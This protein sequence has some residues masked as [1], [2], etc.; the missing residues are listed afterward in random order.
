M[1]LI[2]LKA[3]NFK[4]L[5]DFE[6]NFQDGLNVIVGEN[7]QGKTT[8]LQ[9]IEAALFGPT[10]VPGKKENIPTWGQTKFTLTLTFVTHEATSPEDD[11]YYSLTRT[12]TT[13][14]LERFGYGEEELLANGNTPV[15]K[16][17]EELL[18]L[19]A[20]DYNLFMQSKQGET[21]GVLTF[22]AS[23]LNQKV[24]EF[25]GVSLIDAIQR[26]ANELSATAK[27]SS[28]ALVVDE[29]YM[30]DTSVK[31]YA[32]ENSHAVAVSTYE[33]AQD[34]VANYQA[35]IAVQPAVSSEALSKAQREAMR[36]ASSLR[37]A[38]ADYERAIGGSAAADQAVIDA[39]S[40]VVVGDLTEAVKVARS[41]LA[42]ARSNLS[43]L[44]E[45]L[46]SAINAEAQLEQAQHDLSECPDVSDALAVA[47]TN[48]I[49]A[50]SNLEAAQGSLAA[51]RA[52][53]KNLRLLEEG[54]ACPT[55]GTQ[56]SEHDPKALSAEIS[57]AES[58]V[59]AATEVLTA[60]RTA[61]S[62]ATA[63]L[64]NLN[65]DQSKRATL[66][67]AVEKWMGKTTD[68][69]V[70]A[71]DAALAKVFEQRVET[72]VSSVADTQAQINSG[73]ETNARC[74]KATT[75][76]IKARSELDT[77]KA[78]L[79]T[80][81][82]LPVVVIT[83]VEID[84]AAQAE[85]TYRT[86]V[87]TWN[88]GKV[89]V[90]HTAQLAKSELTSATTAL[91]SAD[92]LVKSLEKQAAAARVASEESAL[93][94][95]LARFLRDRRQS[96]LQ[97]VWDTVMAAASKQVKMATANLI[98]QVAYAG[99]E[100][101]FEEDG[102]MA[103]VTSASGAQKAHIG[104]AVRIGL[105]RALYGSNSLLILDEPTESMSERNA[106]GLSASLVGA[107]KQTL[108]ITHREQDQSL[109]ANIIQLGA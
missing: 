73:E 94:S 68:K 10:V 37:E 89:A 54:A 7:A 100:F 6:C 11:W 19:T 86:E 70:I 109:A 80:L 24:E 8:L 59:S 12:G 4:K 25:A 93:A 40:A 97:Q 69:W 5:S 55:C 64:S 91:E 23:A 13:A 32:A 15:T 44:N 77:A 51:A 105:A 52:T 45:K 82:A 74:N 29:E 36:A 28:E 67:T 16:Y 92:A 27:A 66:A 101:Q 71:E 78:L 72:L 60:A 61:G 33:N 38:K 84:T 81:E 17:I 107:A 90:T 48:S 87:S 75:A 20:K 58:V 3:K 79:A 83:D 21:A 39:G 9:A 53:L 42:T 102:V 41:E 34:V 47:A 106:L 63:A 22:G 85:A 46:S 31:L 98:T 26:R 56:L 2:S 65:R 14:K 104:T 57:A 108:L 18:G 43:E 62:I 1:K 49:T 35:L 88:T 95:R 30:D 103:P 50:G 96:Y 99:G 76:A